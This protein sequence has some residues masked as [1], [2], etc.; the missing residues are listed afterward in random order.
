VGSSLGEG[1]APETAMS[2]TSPLKVVMIQ[3][4]QFQVH[5]MKLP[6]SQTPCSVCKTVKIGVSPSLPQEINAAIMK[7]GPQALPI[8]RF[9][10]MILQLT[11][12]HTLIW[13]LMVT[14]TTITTLVCHSLGMLLLHM[15]SLLLELSASMTT[16]LVM[17]LEIP[18]LCTTITTTLAAVT[19]I[20][21][22]SPHGTN[23]VNAE[24]VSI[25]L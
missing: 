3:R 9:M 12:F 15:S 10:V 21:K 13:E 6:L 17:L 16:L 11:K 8:A 14:L 20:P 1:L 18:A 7:D 22:T 23:A 5:A 24:A 2:I 25:I 4:I 19:G